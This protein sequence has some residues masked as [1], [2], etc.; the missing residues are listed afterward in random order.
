MIEKVKKFINKLPK[1]VKVSAYILIS[2]G[3][4]ELIKYLTPLEIDSAVLTGIVNIAL[5]FL[6]QFKARLDVIRKK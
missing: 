3:I 5:V 2:F 1:E 6:A 4:G